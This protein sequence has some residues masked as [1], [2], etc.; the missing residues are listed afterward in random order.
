MMMMNGGTFQ[1]EQANMDR[2]RRRSQ[3]S[4]SWMFISIH[5]IFYF[6]SSLLLFISTFL[7]SITEPGVLWMDEEAIVCG[8]TSKTKCSSVLKNGIDVQ[9]ARLAV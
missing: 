5:L 6:Y 4:W 2:E 8:G 9:P 7:N 3:S 1:R